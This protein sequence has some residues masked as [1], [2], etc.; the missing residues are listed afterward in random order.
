[1]E[2]TKTGSYDLLAN[3]PEVGADTLPQ[4]FKLRCEQHSHEVYMKEKYRGIW[5]EYSWEE[6]YEQIKRLFLGLI[7]LGLKRGETVAICGENR[8]Q[9]Y[10]TEYASLAAGAKVVC[11]YPDMMPRE[12][13]YTLELSDTVY[14]VVEDQEQVDKALK[15]KDDLPLLRRIIYWDI[16]GMYKYRDPLLV[17]FQDVQEE[18]DKYGKENPLLFEMSI[19]QGKADDIAVLLFTSGTTGLPKAAII[20]HRKLLDTAFSMQKALPLKPGTR[21]LSYMSP[22]WMTEQ[23]FG[24]TWGLLAP[25]TIHFF[26]EPETVQHDIRE[27]GAEYLAFGARQWE[28]FAGLIQS[29]M[30]EAGPIR[31]LIYRFGLL[32]GKKTSERKAGDT[33]VSFFWNLLKPLANFFVL[34]K[35]LDFLGLSKAKLTMNGGGGLSPEIFKFYRALGIELRSSYGLTEYGMISVHRM[36]KVI[37]GETLGQLLTSHSSFGPPLEWKIGEDGEILLRGGTGFIGYYK[38]QK[39]T[40]ESLTEGWYKTGDAGYI[41]KNEELVF[42]DRLKDMRKLSTGHSFPPQFIEIRLRFSPYIKDVLVLGD[43]EKEFVAA[44]VNIDPETIGTWAEKKSIAYST[45]P[46]LSQNKLVCGLISSQIKEVN[47]ILPPESRIKR[48]VNLAKELDPD[49]AELTRSRK[50]KRDVIETKYKDMIECIYGD[51]K[52]YVGEVPV[53]YRD[54][55]TGMIIISTLINEVD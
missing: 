11:L 34:K 14:F 28:S 15:I 40:N 10:L 43:T 45:F 39:A 37:D 7:N 22:A 29:R 55:R 32:V 19:E 52:E 48:F 8:I 24:L 9:V 49:E 33:E 25:F 36:G 2:N 44:L 51:K 3:L 26:E 21:Y 13:Q 31:Q 12:I 5:K 18:G 53:K 4:L 35:I 38:N 23:N 42:L 50:L 54:G 6:I 30:S 27:I 16:R 17:N 46:D 1:M 20:T 47:R 41:S